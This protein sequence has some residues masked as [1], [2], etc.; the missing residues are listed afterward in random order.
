M[1]LGAVVGLSHRPTTSQRSADLS[2]FLQTLNTD[3]QS[4]AGGVR[5]SLYVLRTTDSGASHDIPTAVS[6]ASTGAT[7]CLPTNNDPLAGLTGEQPPESL[8]SYHLDRA[9]NALLTWGAIDASAVCTDVAAVLVSRGQPGEAAARAALSRDLTRM[10]K[11]RATVSA[12]LK[13]AVKALAP[14]TGLLA[15][16]G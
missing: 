13:P 7:N 5:D 15:L 11:Q 12:L 1:L 14:K 8:L 9:T 3:V 4:C 6:V 2:E 16:P 10:D